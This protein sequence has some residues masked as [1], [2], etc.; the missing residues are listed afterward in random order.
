MTLK[1]P[2][3]NGSADGPHTVKGAIVTLDGQLVNIG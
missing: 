2:V 3:I 1:A